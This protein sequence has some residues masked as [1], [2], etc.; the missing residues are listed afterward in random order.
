MQ[1]NL[2]KKFLSFSYGSW[3]GLII[4]L[5]S[6]MI[7]T[8]ILDPAHFGKASMFTLVINLS[9]MIVILGTDQSFV[10]FFY[11]ESEEN[12]GGLLYNCITLPLI[13][14]LIFSLCIIFFSNPISVF[15]F[16]EKNLTVMVV[17]AI[18]IIVQVLNRY[19]VLVVRMQQKGNLFSII[20][21]SNRVLNLMT[22]LLLY[23]IFGPSYKIIIY[24][25]VISLLVISVYVIFKEKKFWH[26]NNYNKKNLKHSKRDVLRFG[27][28]LVL[29]TLITWLFTSF[30]K[31]A[32]RQF[33]TYD[34]LGIYAAAFRLVSL[35]AVLQTTFSTFW[36]PVAFERYEK[37]PDD[38][39]FY[40]DMNRIITFSMFFVA[41]LTILGKDIII[42][43]LG[44]NYQETSKIMPFLVFMPVMY[45]ISETTVIGINFYKKTKWHILIASVSCVINIFGN[46][47]LVP[48]YGALGAS[49]STA[50]SYIIFFT[51]RTLVSKMYYKVDYGLKKFYFV[52]AVLSVYA[53]YSI[54]TSNQIYNFGFGLIALL[55]LIVTYKNDV[56]RYY[57][58]VRSKICSK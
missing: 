1:D 33:S 52:T 16:G 9:M 48:T 47:L 5:L 57:K 58:I 11:E 38:T 6:T 42:I 45:T 53:F 40:S 51:L 14:G 24:S 27:V 15:L 12:R 13:F 28:P 18:G 56:S 19:A 4:G 36:S 37:K 22:L 41:S 7:T 44:E 39:N 26:L 43:L 17:L 32:I 46:L 35:V 34:E 31:I 25:T 21:I 55:I 20:E 50:F 23:F 54:S 29:T 49:I 10:R 3:A 8:R 30:D 2:L